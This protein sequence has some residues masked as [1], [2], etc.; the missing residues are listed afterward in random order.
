VDDIII[1][2]EN[3]QA[4]MDAKDGSIKEPDLHIGANIKNK[5]HVEG[6]GEPSKTQCAMSSTDQYVKKAV[7]EGECELGEVVHRLA[8]KA[9]VPLALSQRPE[10]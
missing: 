8:V 5:W 4:V 10:L 9:T 6:S 1:A 7:A 2:L 3:L